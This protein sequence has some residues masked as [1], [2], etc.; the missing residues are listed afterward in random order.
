MIY[1]MSPEEFL[2]QMGGQYLTKA[3][4]PEHAAC[5]FENPEFISILNGALEC[6]QYEALDYAGTPAGIRME[7]GELMCCSTWLDN[8]AE[9]TF[10]RVQSGK[11]LSYIGWPTTD[12]SCGSV[13]ALYGAI[14]AFS[15]TACPEGC[16][17]FIKFVLQN[18]ADSGY[19]YYGSPV[20][21]PLMREQ[22]AQRNESAGKYTMATE[23]DVQAYIAAAKACQVMGYRDESVMKIMQEECAPLLRGEGTAEDAARR[24]QARVSL[25]M[26]EQYS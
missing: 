19:S 11:R 18:A 24:I 14:S 20:Y 3:L 6:G 13:A 21:A 5:D 10:D 25:Y 12:G 4:D 16:W 22:V 26:A 2:T 15:S 7:T 23:E 1:Y 17:E 9:V 8:P